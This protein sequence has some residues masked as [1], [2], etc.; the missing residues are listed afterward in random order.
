MG[1]HELLINKSPFSVKI[2]SRFFVVAPYVLC[3]AFQENYFHFGDADTEV[4]LIPALASLVSGHQE[5]W[6]IYLAV[7]ALS[8]WL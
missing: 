3:G 5:L 4:H 7:I 1:T 6:C 2:S 8:V